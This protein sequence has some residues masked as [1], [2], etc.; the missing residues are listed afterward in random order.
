MTPPTSSSSDSSET[1]NADQLDTFDLESDA[2][3]ELLNLPT[4]DELLEL[5]GD[6]ML[7]M[8]D[9]EDT[10][11]ASLEAE[12]MLAGLAM[13]LDDG[14]DGVD[15]GSLLTE[16]EEEELRFMTASTSFAPDFPDLEDM[17]TI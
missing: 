17:E 12:D 11:E 7:T 5:Q 8:D 16:R 6:E 10:P 2:A 9:K 15:S 3:G 1:S 4:V 13:E 14:L